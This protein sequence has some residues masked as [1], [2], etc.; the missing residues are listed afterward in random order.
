M[1]RASGVLLPLFSLPGG[2]SCGSLGRAARTWID[3]IREAGFSVW[4]ILPVGIPDEHHSPYL[5]ASSFGGNPFYL[6]PEL[7]FEEGLLSREELEGAREETPYLCEYDRLNR[8][9]LALLC[10]AAGRVADRGPVERFIRENPRV[11]DTC[12]FLALKEKN[13]GLP[14]WEWTEKTPD[15]AALFAWQWMQYEFARQWDALHDYA[16]AAGVSILGDLPFYVA[17]DSADIWR[18]PAQF[19]LDRKGRPKA[20]AG[21]PPDYF[22]ADGQLWGNP[23][24]DWAHMKRDGYS[25]WRERAAYAF[26][27]YDALRIDHFRAAAAYWSVPAGAETAREGHWETGPGMAFCRMLDEAG[28]G[29]PV[30]AE[31]LGL[32]D[33]KVDSLLSEAGYPG[34]AVFQFGFDGDPKNPHLP[35]NYT[36]HLAA[37]PGTHDNNTLLGFL[38]ELD[39]GTRARVFEYLGLPADDWGRNCREILR[40]LWMS[41]AGLLILPLP[42][43]LGYGADTRF[44]TPGRAEGNWRVRFTAEQIAS[45]DTALFRRWNTLYNR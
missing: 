39:E 7:L 43:L 10:R 20:V 24:Y 33:E 17:L 27:L 26:S 45:I 41:A 29:K 21:V 22:S 37:Y 19:Q 36:P 28:G 9:R 15:E 42:D 38:W 5:S 6:D 18:D 3:T 12:L 40:A 2:F 30:L 4:Q 11:G 1:K 32:I 8:E 35:H 16:K 44:N 23:L 34:M 31:N 25:Y 13:G 14:W